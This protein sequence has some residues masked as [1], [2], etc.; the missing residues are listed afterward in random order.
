MAS[1]FAPWWRRAL[2][3]V[4]G[5]F[6]KC[7]DGNMHWRWDRRCC[8]CIGSNGQR[9]YTR[10]GKHWLMDPPAGKGESHGA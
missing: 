8:C 5:L 4:P 7:P 9:A 6:V 2:Y 3:Y 10:L 1:G